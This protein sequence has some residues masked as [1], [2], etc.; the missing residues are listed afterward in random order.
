MRTMRKGC[1]GPMGSP[2][3]VFDRIIVARKMASPLM[4][5]KVRF[6]EGLE[7]GR[8]FL[9]R[10]EGVTNRSGICNVVQAKHSNNNRYPLIN[11]KRFF[12]FS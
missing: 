2:V 10:R 3:P 6:F 5:R 4:T 12:S 8:T 11:Q 9:Q 7:S 1:D